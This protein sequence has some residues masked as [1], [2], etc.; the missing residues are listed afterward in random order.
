MKCCLETTCSNPMLESVDNQIFCFNCYGLYE[1]GI[2]KTI[3]QKYQCCDNPNILETPI[4]NICT[5][6]GNIEMI[7][8]E[9]PSFF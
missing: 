5:N 3:Y 2:K 1:K 6:C 7:Y 9:E 8:T 4:Q